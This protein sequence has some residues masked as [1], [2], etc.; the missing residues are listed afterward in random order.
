MTQAL[1]L[2]SVPGGTDR[3]DL[4]TLALAGS[5]SCIILQ[6]EEWNYMAAANLPTCFIACDPLEENLDDQR[7]FG[8]VIAEK[9]N[10]LKRNVA[11]SG[12]PRML[13]VSVEEQIF[14]F[15]ISRLNL[16][17]LGVTYQ[18]RIEDITR[19]RTLEQK[20][21]S[22]QKE[23]SH[24]SKNMLAVIQ[25]IASQ[26][27]RH[28][29]NLQEFLKKFRDRLHSLSH[30][31]DLITGSSW[32]G[33]RFF[34]LVQQQTKHLSS[35]DRRLFQVQG[36][37]VLLTPNAALHLGLAMHE[38]VV[39]AFNHGTVFSTRQLPITV[40]CMRIHETDTEAIRFVWREPV[41]MD[42][43]AANQNGARYMKHFG[44]TVLEHV[45]PASVNGE[46]DYRLGDEAVTYI[47]TFPL[48]HRD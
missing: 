26:T 33:A 40:T 12:V 22:L 34:D 4:L 39:N 30:S 23:G 45:V 20:L 17:Q 35:D 47:L 9:L 7:V 3:N 14:R 10:D 21:H 48:E 41:Q 29:A 31:Q 27:A 6:D 36:D 18:T 19:L 42:W 38:L 1:W 32:R 15:H 13:E 5:A 28:S 46:A 16:P 43:R 11:A 25:S 37:N 24:R 8:T 44:S 2:Q